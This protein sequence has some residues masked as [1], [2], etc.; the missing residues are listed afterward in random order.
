MLTLKTLPLG[1]KWAVGLV[2][3]A[4]VVQAPPMA[5][6]FS[7]PNNL[8]KVSPTVKQGQTVH[9]QLD[10]GKVSL[11]R[12]VVAKALGRSVVLHPQPNGT[13][14]GFLPIGVSTTTGIV[15]ITLQDG[16]GSDLG[17]R[18]F[19]ITPGFFPV[20]NIRVSKQ[21][22]G[23]EPLPGEMEAVQALKNA[24][25]ALK[26]WETPFISPTVD[27]E[28]SPFG[29]L[30]AHNGKLTGDYHKGVDLRSPHGRPVR[31][32]AGGR[33]QISKAFRLHGGTVGIDHGQGFSSIYIHMSK[34]AV[35]EGDMVKQ[36]EIIGLVG[37]TGFASGP[38]LHWGMYVN[39]LPV[40][41]NQW[42]TGVSKCY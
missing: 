17:N 23:L 7:A 2:L 19:T 4:C 30:R 41:P 31:A 1:Y 9:I 15:P 22:K 42:V 16:Q 13:Y 29:V 26:L 10:V 28:N 5:T 20:Q 35:Q 27:C 24:Q 39:G 34:R 6:V 37:A 38:H 32:I 11:T 25:T 8:I 12:P 18:S 21:T 36:G 14:E 3:L 33:V 40:N